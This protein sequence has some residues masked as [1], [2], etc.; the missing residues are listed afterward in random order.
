MNRTFRVPSFLVA[1]LAALTSPRLVLAAGG[2]ETGAFRHALEG[3]VLVAL[4][5]SYVFGVATSLTPCVNDGGACSPS[6]WFC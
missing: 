3:G 1:A 4:A 2:S 5:T 6:L